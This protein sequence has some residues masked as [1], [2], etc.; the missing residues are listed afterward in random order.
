LDFKTG[1]GY[2]VAE[3]SQA[4]DYS[5]VGNGKFTGF[6]IKLNDIVIVTNYEATSTGGNA[7]NN[8]PQFY[9]LIIPPYTQVT[10]QGST[11]SAANNPF[12]HTIKGRIYK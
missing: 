3:F 4:I 5:N 12:F 8:M 11:D 1:A 9:R 7:E 2:I 10:T 6:T